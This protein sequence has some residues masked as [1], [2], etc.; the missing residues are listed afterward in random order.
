MFLPPSLPLLWV[1]DD[2]QLLPL[3]STW[4]W[5]SCCIQWPGIEWG[6]WPAVQ[7]WKPCTVEYLDTWYLPTTIEPLLEGVPCSL[8][9]SF[10]P[11]NFFPHSIFNFLCSLLFFIFLYTL[12]SAISNV[13]FQV[14]V[15]VNKVGSHK[16]QVND[17]KTLDKNRD[18]WMGHTIFVSL[19]QWN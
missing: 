2:H 19:C 3:A 17:F 18:M 4:T 12:K 15:K 16:Q 14:F 1:W 6:V 5:D 9:Q 8:F 10:A 11:F 7:V 13:I